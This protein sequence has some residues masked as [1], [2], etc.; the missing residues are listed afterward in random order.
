VEIA[1]SF[2]AA[3]GCIAC[4]GCGSRPL[5]DDLS[6]PSDAR[7]E[8]LTP[9]SIIPT[10]NPLSIMRLDLSTIWTGGSIGVPVVLTYS[11]GNSATLTN[12]TSLG[13]RGDHHEL[14]DYQKAAWRA[15]MAI[16]SAASGVELIEA[17][18]AEAANIVINYQ[19]MENYTGLGWVSSPNSSLQSKIEINARYYDQ[20]ESMD[21]VVGGS[22]LLVFMLHEIG[23][24]LG[25]KHPYEGYVQ[26]AKSFDHR[27]YTVM[28]HT[29]NPDG[30]FRSD[31]SPLDRAALELAYGSQEAQES[32]ATQWYQLEGGGLLSVSNADSSV[33]NG[34]KDRDYIIAG[35]G[36]DTI[37]AGEGND[38]IDSGTG[39]NFIYG[40]SG[41]DI[42]RVYAD[43]NNFNAQHA[44]KENFVRT[45]SE[46]WSGFFILDGRTN[47]FS[48]IEALWFDDGVFQIQATPKMPSSETLAIS[49]RMHD[50]VRGVAASDSWKVNRLGRI[51][52]DNITIDVLARELA[53]NS[54][55]ADMRSGT[56]SFESFSI[57]FRRAFGVEASSES[58]EL[59]L[60]AESVSKLLVELALASDSSE[61]MRTG[62][63]YEF[64]R[65]DSSDTADQSAIETAFFEK[66]EEGEATYGF[67]IK[68]ET[69]IISQRSSADVSELQILDHAI[70][71][72]LPDGRTIEVPDADR[73]EF[74][75]GLLDFRASNLET[76]V[77]RVYEFLLGN[78]LS[79]IEAARLADSVSRNDA[80]SAISILLSEA[81]VTRRISSLS[82]E[83]FV[84]SVYR[85]LLSREAN[86]QEIN[87]SLEK[88][89]SGVSKSDFL[90][91]FILSDEV[92]NRLY[93]S[94]EGGVFFE[95]WSDKWIVSLFNAV[96]HRPILTATRDN[97]NR[98][99][100]NGESTL[101]VA[102]SLVS[103]AEAL[104]RY[105]GYTDA[106]FAKIIYQNVYGVAMPGEQGAHIA[107]LME[108]GK[109]RGYIV[110]LL[111]RDE[112][113][114]R[115]GADWISVANPPSNAAFGDRV[116]G[117]DG[118]DVL[119]GR[120]WGDYIDGGNGD[121][122][123]SGNSGDDLLVGGDGSDTLLGGEGNDTL[124]GG[125]GN[126]SLVGGA[127]NDTFIVNKTGVQIREVANQGTDAVH[128]SL[129]NYSL[130]SFI[131]NLVATNG[132]AHRF[133]GNALNNWIV[134]N[135]GADTL[136]GGAGD[137]TLDGGAGGDSLVG[138][139]GNDTYVVDHRA[140]RV[141]ES[142]AGTDVVLT[143]LAVYAL[144]PF[145]EQ[146]VA[147]SAIAHK[148]TGNAL[149]NRI[150][151]HD[152]ADTLIGQHGND[153]LD[154]GAG[155]DR[156][157]GGVGNDTY[158]IGPGDVIVELAGQGVDT[159]FVTSGTA[160]NLGMHLESLV[161][162]G[163]SLISGTGNNLSNV[164]IGNA[165]G[166]TLSGGL[167]N[168]VLYGDDGDDTLIGGLGQDT[169]RGGA[170]SDEFKFTA[171]NQS[172][173]N[174]P[175]LIEG[176]SRTSVDL[177]VISLEMIDANSLVSGNQAFKFQGTDFTGNAGDLRVQLARD[178]LYIAAGDINGDMI[179]DFAIAISSVNEPTEA[180][181]IL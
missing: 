72:S 167:G 177:D 99:L 46:G 35:G 124:D 170:G 165:A 148:F 139:V 162:E 56:L 94:S 174:T 157:I 134:G 173:E 1:T 112:L 178:G 118:N 42:L 128:T 73:V 169:L 133:V 44:F 70:M 37:Y 52:S 161:L 74:L 13:T 79:E 33:I 125:T 111:V 77:S 101:K 53:N 152:G 171:A 107:S 76:F 126:D 147:T 10:D 54:P 4:G 89:R 14:N 149:A 104:S 57:L 153:T 40:G 115:R 5:P 127:G 145:V 96:F 69:T 92:I 102:S 120:F 150:T 65:M 30:T 88:M 164:I 168:D 137:D 160:Y 45:S 28:S 78:E 39:D 131:E 21:L 180:W 63:G 91:S 142:G 7:V 68:S 85:A 59:A 12:S 109:S 136:S 23:H 15:A 155:S 2:C 27:G 8:T 58:F 110:E 17:Q 24:S 119:K 181:F 50:I 140:D 93:S 43:S 166:N 108:A 163:A 36:N 26:L 83:S 146:L 156:L 75:D 81:S 34:I 19:T 130:P 22:D 116:I 129:P 64:V 20:I 9:D 82:G 66:L 135:F 98:G 132:V 172:A 158:I 106:D 80:S 49:V 95:S 117:S 62:V 71:V 103:S 32:L 31:L 47:T 154:G 3:G 105:E 6:M 86:G 141:L 100:E 90:Y 143:T 159:V 175:D 113:D 11:F 18:N 114:S 97:Q 51:E 84:Q 122:M 123:I 87:D 61:F 38:T 179:A 60:K 25:M 67:R 29:T 176:F 55:F 151:G 138:G 144:P 16:H 48:G 41:F 121:D